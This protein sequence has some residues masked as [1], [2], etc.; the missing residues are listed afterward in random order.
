MYTRRLKIYSI[1]QCTA[2][3]GIKHDGKRTPISTEITSSI[4]KSHIIYSGL[5]YNP[6]YC[7]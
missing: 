4:S 6:Q 1:T 5:E 3:M 2:T 7:S